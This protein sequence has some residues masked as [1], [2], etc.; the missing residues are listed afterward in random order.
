MPLGKLCRKRE[1]I[2]AV[3]NGVMR[4]GPIGERLFSGWS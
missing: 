2:V 3:E 1:L 4:R